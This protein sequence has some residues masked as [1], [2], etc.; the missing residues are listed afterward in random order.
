ML[1]KDALMPFVGAQDLLREPQHE[2]GS[3]VDRRSPPHAGVGGSWAGGRVFS[4]A[5]HFG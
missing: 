1:K 3:P 2:R 5:W 4:A